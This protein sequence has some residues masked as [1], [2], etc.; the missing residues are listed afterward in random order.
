MVSRLD[1]FVIGTYLPT[2]SGW[3][4]LAVVTDLFSRKIVGWSVSKSLATPL[5]TSAL[6][7]AIGNRRP[8]TGE[9]PHHSVRGWRCT[10]SEFRKML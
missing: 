2:D 3:G 4:Y 8:S 5:V 10:S 1:R 9:L 6:R 7:R